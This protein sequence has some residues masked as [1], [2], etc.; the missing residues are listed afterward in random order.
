MAHPKMNIRWRAVAVLVVLSLIIFAINAAPWLVVSRPQKSDAIVV[1]AGETDQ[2]PQLA[3]K[4]LDAGYAPVMM[5]NVPA[6]QRVYQ[7][8]SPELA[9][10][11]IST[12]PQAPR[13]KICPIYGL[14]TKAEARDAAGCLQKISARTVLLV[15]SDFHTRRALSTFQHELPQ[16]KFSVAA[17]HSGQ[18]FGPKWWQHRE[19]AKTTLYEWMRL[20][21]W[22]GVDR[23]R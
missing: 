8:T 6:Q 11:W 13:I 17:A 2:R 22:Q 14:S 20:M 18:E 12:L 5:L 1:L 4:L 19:W 3:L 9:E 16:W 21:W 10:R 23:W 15:T 7:W